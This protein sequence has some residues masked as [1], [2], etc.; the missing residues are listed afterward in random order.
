MLDE[1]LIWCE[2]WILCPLNKQKTSGQGGDLSAHPPQPI[3]L[4]PQPLTLAFNRCMNVS[5]VYG[6][7]Y[8]S[9]I[10]RLIHDPLQW[11]YYT[12]DI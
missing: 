5:V 2:W 8:V 7:G 9:V 10:L 6:H 1:Y 11:C 3:C 4:I 12:Y